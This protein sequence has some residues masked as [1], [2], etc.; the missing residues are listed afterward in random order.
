MMDAREEIEIESEE[1]EDHAPPAAAKS[2]ICMWENSLPADFCEETISLFEDSEFPQRLDEENFG[3]FEMDMLDP[4]ILESLPRWKEV[5]YFVMQRLQR[6]SELYRQFYDIAFFP[7]EA[8]NENLI[9]R[10]YLPKD[11]VGYHSHTMLPADHKRFLSINFFLN[12]T[13]HGQYTLPDYNIGIESRLGRV[14]IHP[15][16]WTHPSQITSS[17]SPRYVISTFLRYR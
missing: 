4:N 6:Y 9:M 10:K 14:L 5:S 12:D 16:Y 2:Y 17:E 7:A 3:C 8:I 15:S 11:E 13:E 1:M